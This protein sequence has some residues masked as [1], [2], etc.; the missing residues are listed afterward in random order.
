MIRAAF[1]FSL[2]LSVA[3]MAADFDAKVEHSYA[4]SNGVKI[5]YASYGPKDGSVIVMVHGFPDFWYTWRAQMEALG[6][7]GFRTVALD[8]RGYNL[9]GQPAGVESYDMRL[10]V[11]DV[12]SVIRAQGGPKV[13]LLGH[14]WG[15]AISW[16]VAFNAPQ[17]LERL[18]I[19]NLPHP[20]GLGRELANNPEQQKNSAY[21][22]S[23]QEEGSEKKLTAE[24]LA[25]WV[26]DEEARRKYV[27]AFGRSSFAGMMAYYQRN[28]PKPPY[29]APSG[30]VTALKI[31]T[32]MIHG[33][34]DT[35]LL[36]PALN[37]TWDWVEDLTLVTIPEAGHFVQQD[38][39]AKVSKSVK[40]WMRREP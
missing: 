30:P 9:S 15:G 28:Y 37:G 22:R 11:G 5:H 29:A 35:A 14:D 38:A 4:D 12:I 1:C 26:K 25:R 18:V 36:S 16:Q 6:D 3:G 32:L 17:L 39:A 20:R 2:M 13:T 33:L 27:E 40:M 34:G 10:L 24:G 8:L 7:A 21:A 23:F 19:L 31:P